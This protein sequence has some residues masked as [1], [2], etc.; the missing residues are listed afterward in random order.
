[1][2]ILRLFAAT[3]LL[4]AVALPV[5]AQQHWLIGSWKGSL[6]GITT[7]NPYGTERTLKIVSVDGSTAKGQWIGPTGAQGVAVTVNGD[8][9]SFATPG[10]LGASYRLTHKGNALDGSWQ[11][12]SSG[13]SGS[14]NLTKQ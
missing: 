8:S 5:H 2:P 4:L 6:G 11:G 14:V 3:A 1:M 13:K 7:S 9:V 10:G 12:T